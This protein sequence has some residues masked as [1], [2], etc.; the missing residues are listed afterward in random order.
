MLDSGL[1]SI[2]HR[3]RTH[4]SL[5][6]YVEVRVREENEMLQWTLQKSG[7]GIFRLADVQIGVWVLGFGVEDFG[8]SK[9]GC[10]PNMS[11]SPMHLVRLARVGNKIKS[12]LAGSLAI[13][14]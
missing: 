11:Q 8:F 3:V 7:C 6:F 10:K 13:A 9:S 1:A 12:Q 5:C 4:V 2:S 14:N